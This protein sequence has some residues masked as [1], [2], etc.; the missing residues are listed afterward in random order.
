MSAEADRVVVS[1][2]GRSFRMWDVAA[3][4]FLG[5]PIAPPDPKATLVEVFLSP[6]GR[7]VLATVE[8]QADG[9]SA[10]G[11]KG[12]LSQFSRQCTLWEIERAVPIAGPWAFQNAPRRGARISR[13]G[14]R[15][16]LDS[17]N[18]LEMRDTENGRL[19]W[20]QPG[21]QSPGTSVIESPDGTRVLVSRRGGPPGLVSGYEVRLLDA[22][23]GE[24]IAGGEKLRGSTGS[25]G[26]DQWST[27][28]RLLFEYD[29]SCVWIWDIK[30]CTL[31][32]KY[33]HIFDISYISSSPDGRRFL[34]VHGTSV[35]VWD[36]ATDAPLTPLLNHPGLVSWARFGPSGTDVL[37]TSGKAV[38]VW[39]LA[40]PPHGRTLNSEA[41]PVRI[42]ARSP[43]GRLLFLRTVA[44]RVR[45]SIGSKSC[46][47]PAVGAFPWPTPSFRRPIAPCPLSSSAPTPDSY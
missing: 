2:D 47:A 33:D 7:R 41:D 35:R 3:G 34:T 28:G 46:T 45:T 4:K 12:S 21:S 1:E 37:A 38:F 42:D 14:K 44:A 31:I 24:S 30:T 13:D 10:K 19:L 32:G 11:K 16:L 29:T 23:T 25:N 20:S 6:D 39:P 27:D 40:A 8:T 9:P 22:A 26:R 18:A 15:V 5:D 43:D 17:G 36:T